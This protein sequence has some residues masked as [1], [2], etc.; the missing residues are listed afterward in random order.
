[1]EMQGIVILISCTICYKLSAVMRRCVGFV[2]EK[3]PADEPGYRAKECRYH[4]RFDRAYLL[5]VHLRLPVFVALAQQYA[6]FLDFRRGGRQRCL[7]CL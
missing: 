7:G 4:R 3:K 6:K 1:M 5:S 2:S